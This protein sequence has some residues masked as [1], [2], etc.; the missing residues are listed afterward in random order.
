VGGE[1][2]LRRGSARSSRVCRRYGA[3]GRPRADVAGDPG[4]DRL[5]T[6]NRRPLGEIDVGALAIGDRPRQ[7]GRAGGARCW[8]RRAPPRRATAKTSSSSPTPTE[9]QTAGHRGVRHHQEDAVASALGCAEGL[10]AREG[11][12]RR[13]RQP[14]QHHGVRR[15]SFPNP[16]FQSE[17]KNFRSAFVELNGIEPSASSMP[18]R[19]EMKKNR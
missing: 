6:G 15:Q 3:I 14:P 2:R 18:F 10:G 19:G 5:V 16:Y 11:G 1:A 9:T 4:T 8:P 12:W 13:E 17:L 7:L